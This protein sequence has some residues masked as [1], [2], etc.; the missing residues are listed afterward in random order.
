[1]NKK[2]LT[3][4]GIGCGLLLLTGCG[5]D[6]NKEKEKENK[7]ND[8]DLVCTMLEDEEGFGSNESNVVIHY[9]KNWEKI[10][11]IDMEM[12][13][14]LEDDDMVEMYEGFLAEMCE[15]EDAPEECEVKTKGNKVTLTATGN[16][17]VLEI[18]EDMT[19]EDVIEL[20]EDDGF[21]CK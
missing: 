18:E 4:F 13:V 17:E 8:N 11:S 7:K 3:L 12:I 21:T 9:D 10:E 19:K 15:E 16:S 2:Y 5:D 6:T 20:M 1:M 14:E